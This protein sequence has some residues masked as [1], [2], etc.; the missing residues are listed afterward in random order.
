MAAL[1]LETKIEELAR[2]DRRYGAESYQFVFEALDYVLT[3]PGCRRNPAA[4]HIAVVEL[5]E[6]MRRLGLERFGPLARCVFESWGVYSTEDFGEIVFRLIAHDLL[7]QGE[8][9][10]KEDFAG[11]FDFGEAF[12]QAW[13]PSLR[14]HETR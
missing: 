10:R 14:L 9:D 7:H 5:L 11:G 8:H 4:R 1:S 2:T 12:E 13:R 6:G 3:H